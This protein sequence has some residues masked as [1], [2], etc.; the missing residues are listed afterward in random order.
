MKVGD[1]VKFGNYLGK[2]ILWRVINVDNGDECIQN[3]GSNNWENSNIREWLNS[4][5]AKVNYTTQSPTKDAVYE[6]D[7][8]FS[9]ESGFLSNFSSDERSSI[10]PIVHKFVLSES[11]K[12]LRTGGSEKHIW[13]ADIGDCVQNFDEAYYKNFTD[14]VYLLDLKEIHDYVYSRGWEYR[15]MPTEDAIEASNYKN[16]KTL[17][18]QKYW[19]NWTRT[20]YSD[21]PYFVRTIQRN[22][23]FDH[24]GDVNVN[25]SGVAGGIVPAINLKTTIAKSG[26]GTEDDPYIPFTEEDVQDNWKY[27][28]DEKVINSSNKAWTIKFNKSLDKSIINSDNIFVA[29]DKN[30]QNKVENVFVKIGASQSE[31]L[32]NYDNKSLWESGKTYYLF[33]KSDIHSLQKENLKDNIRMKFNVKF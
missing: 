14:K 5:E 26:N 11:N 23:E 20:P 33:I 31:I 30:G 1:Y 15:R 6:G 19:W 8:A 24:G 25:C 12:S 28:K 10:K 16:P 21:N 4:D 22:Q 29:T 27:Y 9:T 17:T 18:C 32:V 2:P 7:N 13:N 3:L